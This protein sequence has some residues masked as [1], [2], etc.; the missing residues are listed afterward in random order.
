MPCGFL[1]LG[2]QQVW[3]WQERLNHRLESWQ[4]HSQ[5]LKI[6]LC[7][8]HGP[9]V[10]LG[11][12]LVDAAFFIIRMHYVFFFVFFF[13]CV[14]ICVFI[15]SLKIL[16]MWH[17]MSSVLQCGV[18]SP[19]RLW[20]GL[21]TEICLQKVSYIDTFFI[22]M[23]C[24]SFWLVLFSAVPEWNLQSVVLQPRHCGSEAKQPCWVA[25]RCGKDQHLCSYNMTHT[26]GLAQHC[27]RALEHNS[28]PIPLIYKM[29]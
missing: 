6:T 23:Q 14:W 4:I 22:H 29:I 1:D 27:S 26:H 16:K 12:W 15:F 8:F 10:M 3:Y 25:C 7:T 24:F 18:S 5:N 13:V 2:H 21:C 17:C 9:G 28:C 19:L 20:L 11:F